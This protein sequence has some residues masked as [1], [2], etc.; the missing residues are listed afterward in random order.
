MN[1]YK[2]PF[3]VDLICKLR[4]MGYGKES[5]IFTSDEGDGYTFL[6][7]YRDDEK[8]SP[9]L[10]S[11]HFI[12]WSNQ[13]KLLIDLCNAKAEEYKKIEKRKMVRTPK[14]NK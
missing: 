13:L 9:K 14:R 8:N 1:E 7:N 10:E 11:K 12:E 3:N 2:R 6:N 4:V 5:F